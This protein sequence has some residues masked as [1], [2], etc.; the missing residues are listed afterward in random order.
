MNLPEGYEP[1]EL[2]P[3]Y[4]GKLFTEGQMKR[5]GDAC[6]LEA[7][8]HIH[9]LWLEPWPISQRTFISRLYDFVIKLR[10]EQ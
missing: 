10:N 5:F 2:P 9:E 3:D 1:H 8:E 4:A 7:A 6:A